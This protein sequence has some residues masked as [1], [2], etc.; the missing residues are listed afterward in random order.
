MLHTRMFSSSTQIQSQFRRRALRAAALSVS[1]VLLAGSGCAR[2]PISP[3]DPSKIGGVQRNAA[4]DQETAP[5]SPIPEAYTPWAGR[6]ARMESVLNGPSPTTG[7]IITGTEP[8]RAITLESAIR[9]SVQNNLE[10]SVSGFGPAIEATRVLEAQARFDPT[11]FSNAGVDVSNR[12]TAGSFIQDPNNNF[13]GILQTEASSTVYTTATGIRQILQGG[14]QVEARYQLRKTDQ[15]PTS[16]ATDPFGEADLV[17]QLTQP[18]LRDFGGQVNQ[19]RIDIA[20]N[21]Q[22]VS[23]L[24]FRQSVE[25]TVANV[26]QTYWQLAA[27][28]KQVEIAERLLERTIRTADI[29]S[30]RLENDAT[31]LQLAQAQADAET[32][33]AVLVRARARVRDLSDRLK[34]LIN[35]PDVAVS[36]PIL[37]VA[38][39]S[40]LIQ[41]IR[42]DQE[43]LLN[44]ATTYRLELAQQQLRTNNAT[45]TLGAAKNNLL[46][47]LNFVG[48]VNPNGLGNGVDTAISSQAE[49][50]NISY[51]AGLQF[52]IP[53]GNRE[54]RAIYRRSMLQRLQSI[55]QY[56]SLVNQVAE[57]VRLRAREVETSWTE[58][59]NF[60]NARFAQEQA[61][62]AIQAQED[63]AEPLTPFFVRNKLDTQ[64]R[65][66]ES[67]NAEV[68]A[69]TAYNVAIS[70]LERA[71]GTLLKYN[72]ISLEENGTAQLRR[73]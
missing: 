16:F 68:Q 40:P 42:F 73:K 54:A 7:P 47:Q 60:R 20:R 44:S 39:S 45:I 57:D 3:F 56:K 17:L 31:K 4:K 48:S 64:A 61:L 43:E 53:I 62:K 28:Q 37:L 35:D 27:A 6:R 38:D 23:L 24:D 46:P 49:F 67:E 41:P 69:L 9:R 71:K 13:A 72:N 19:A 63:A 32:R 34:Q 5:L 26:E 11:F 59:I 55:Q 14:G 29:I 33:R 50:N 30:V 36:S 65:L 8:T 51:A 21:N 22:R 15:N 58:L 66:A 18:L 10:V 52:E 70:Q 1:F 12:Q 25:E 2:D